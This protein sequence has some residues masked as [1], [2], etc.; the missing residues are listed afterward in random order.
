MR[1]INPA[2]VRADFASG[3]ANVAAF[4]ATAQAAI[5]GDRDRTFLVESTFLSAAVLWEGYVSDLFLAYINRDSTRFGQ[6]LH[7][8]LEA[9]LAEKP[10]RIFDAYATIDIPRA[11][12]QGCDREPPGSEGEQHHLP[13]L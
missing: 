5:T 11:P 2:D 9:A 13:E 10:R 8:A 12:H 4:Y 3:L 1:K 6:H 7:D